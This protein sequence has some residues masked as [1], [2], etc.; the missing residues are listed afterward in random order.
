MDHMD[1]DL[2]TMIRKNLEPTTKTSYTIA[3]QMVRYYFIIFSH[4]AIA[5]NVE[6]NF[7]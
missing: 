3:G 1:I 2:E 4:C 5:T 6:P 7:I